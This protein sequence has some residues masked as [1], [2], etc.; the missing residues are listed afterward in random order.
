MNWEILLKRNI[1]VTTG[2]TKTVD[3]PLIEDDENCKVRFDALIQKMKDFFADVDDSAT[4]TSNF[5]NTYRFRNEE[6]NDDVYCI[7][8]QWF[9]YIKNQ[10]S[11]MNLPY[12]RRYRG[13]GNEKYPDISLEIKIESPG[14]RRIRGADKTVVILTV[15]LNNDKIINVKFDNSK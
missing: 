4:N 7:M 11:D 12:Y 2:K 5:V 3:T 8:L 13:M 1:A 10:Y 15:R 6:Y 14:M 9:E